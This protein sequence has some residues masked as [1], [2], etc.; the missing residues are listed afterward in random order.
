M[1]GHSVSVA[2]Q[3]ALETLPRD[4]AG[5]LLVKPEIRSDNG[6]CYISKEFH[7][8]LEHFALTHVKIKPHCRRGS[9]CGNRF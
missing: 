7:G 8:V 9:N 3:A 1:G 5:Q 2:S 4:A 6:S